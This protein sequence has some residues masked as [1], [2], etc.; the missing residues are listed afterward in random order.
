MKFGKRGVSVVVASVLLI[1]LVIVVSSVIFAFARGFVEDK[2]DDGQQVGVEACKGVD[3]DVLVASDPGDNPRAVEIVNRGNY[4]I[5]SFEFKVSY[6]D[7]SSEIKNSSLGVFAGGAVS[8]SFDFS[9]VD[10]LTVEDIEI[11]P[12]L[13]SGAKKVVCREG[14]F[15]L[16]GY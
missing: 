5:S 7:G 6:E 2:M 13:G 3:F 9:G 11:F 16:A 8:G 10:F 4:N 12:V 1:L 14:D 15:Y